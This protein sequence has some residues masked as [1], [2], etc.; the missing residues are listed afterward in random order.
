MYTRIASTMRPSTTRLYTKPSTLQSSTTSLRD[1]DAPPSRPVCVPG[2]KKM[3]HESQNASSIASPVAP[4]HATAPETMSAAAESASITNCPSAV[5]KKKSNDDMR[6]RGRAGPGR[7]RR[8]ALAS[9]RPLALVENLRIVIATRGDRH[10]SHAARR[11]P[12]NSQCA[13][14]LERVSVTMSQGDREPPVV[15]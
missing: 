7:A 14:L 11:R 10:L 9:G 2:S 4:C 3:P 12:A 13:N 8:R 15:F 5:P 6:A 1:I